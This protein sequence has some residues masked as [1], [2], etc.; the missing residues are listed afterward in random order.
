MKFFTLFL[1][2][3]LLNLFAVITILLRPKIFKVKI[4]KPM[5]WNFKLSILPLII[6]ILN[7][8]VFII[9]SAIGAYLKMPAFLLAARI[10]FFIGLAGWLLF[11]PNSGYLITELNLNHRN[12]DEKEVPIWYD[13]VS[14]LAFALSGIM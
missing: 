12:N 4:Y 5:L 13:I 3:V 9:L 10:L 8:A 14:I 6:L 2:V 7:I 1:S 11:L